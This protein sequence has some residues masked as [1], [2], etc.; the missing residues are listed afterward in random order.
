MTAA[1]PPLPGDA[2]IGEDA[3]ASLEAAGNCALSPHIRWQVDG[4]IATYRNSAIYHQDSPTQSGRGLSS[5]QAMRK[6]AQLKRLA[7]A[8]SG[9]AA[10]NALACAK[11]IESRKPQP[12][13][14]PRGWAAYPGLDDLLLSLTLIYQGLPGPARSADWLAFLRCAC[15]QLAGAPEHS[16][17]AFAKR[18]ET[19]CKGLTPAAPARA[20]ITHLK[21]L[22]TRLKST[23][24]GDYIASRMQYIVHALRP[25]CRRR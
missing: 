9:D 10:A 18:A 21:Q 13:G 2:N 6:A 25:I 16:P 23:A 17:E 12:R 20:R 24:L 19:V 22:A 3:W 11:A 4:A 7:A 1:P 15:H 8:L 5:R 14:R